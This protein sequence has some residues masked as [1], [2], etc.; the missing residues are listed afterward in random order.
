MAESGSKTSWADDVEEETN[1]KEQAAAA[2]AATTASATTSTT[3]AATATMEEGRKH[4]DLLETEH[5]VEVTLADMRGDPNSPLYSIKEFRELGMYV[6]DQDCTD[7]LE[8]LH[9][10]TCSGLTWRMEH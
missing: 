5:D 3:P 6:S 7:F 2:A 9:A 4:S 10:V 1:E 8:N